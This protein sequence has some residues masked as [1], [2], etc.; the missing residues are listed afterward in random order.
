MNCFRY[1]KPHRYPGRDLDLQGHVTSTITWPFDSPCTISYRCSIHRNRHSISNRFWNI[2]IQ[3][4]S[5]HDLD[6]LG[7][8]TS[9]TTWPFVSHYMISC[10]CSID[11]DPL[12]WTVF[13]IIHLIAAAIWVATLTFRV[14]WRHRS[15]YHS[16]PTMWFPIGGLLILSSY[17]VRLLRYFGLHVQY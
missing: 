3:M 12:S 8:V 11:T 4:Y 15:H 9:S 13:E 17:L 2:K 5:G 16:T 7:H 1:I 6:L 10:R 14:T